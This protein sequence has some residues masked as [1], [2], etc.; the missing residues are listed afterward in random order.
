MCPR[1]LTHQACHNPLYCAANAGALFFFSH[2]CQ[3]PSA[4]GHLSYI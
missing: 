4:E 2:A 1:Q 3:L